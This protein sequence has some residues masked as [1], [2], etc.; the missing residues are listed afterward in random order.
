MFAK[1]FD[2]FAKWFDAIVKFLNSGFGVM[3]YM[4]GAGFSVILAIVT[5][6]K[7]CLIAVNRFLYWLTT[8]IS[9]IGIPTELQDGM[10][11]AYQSTGLVNA[12]ALFNT[13]FPV[14]EMFSCITVLL[15]LAVIMAV[16]GLVKSWIPTVSG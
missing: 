2:F 16:Y 11:A 9:Q 7:S 14:V 4:L 3:G 6:L 13:F 8:S 10:T 15:A 1:L 12:I 5:F